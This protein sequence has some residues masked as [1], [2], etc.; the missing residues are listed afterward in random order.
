[1]NDLSKDLQAL[2]P[3]QRAVLELRLR[4]RYAD[5][6][7]SGIER[8]NRTS[9]LLPLSF[10]Q[11][12]LWFLDQLQPGSTVFN[13]PVALRLTGQLAVGALEQALTEIVRRHEILRTTFKTVAGQAFQFIHPPRPFELPLTDLTELSAAAHP[14]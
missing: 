13:V 6:P 14:V 10:A 11:Q 5:R 9:D 8:Q 2:S 12:R 4:Q 1:M 7:R 3:K